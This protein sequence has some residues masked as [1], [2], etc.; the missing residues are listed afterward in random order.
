MSEGINKT[1]LIAAIAEEVGLPKT[2]TGKIVDAIFDKIQNAVLA[3]SKVSL[4][5][6][7]VFELRQR[8]AFEGRNPKVAGSVVQVPAKKKIVFHPGKASK[9]A[10]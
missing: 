10:A 6:F 4:R 1:E 8:E 5:G 9:A 2:T 7:G 3:G